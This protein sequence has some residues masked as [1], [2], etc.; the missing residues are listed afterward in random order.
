MSR[1]GRQDADE[2]LLMALACGATVE[3]AAQKAGISRRTAQ[4]RLADSAFRQ[5]LAERRAD[6]VQRTAG[7]LTAAS[8]ESVKTL[9]TLQASPNPAGVRL[10]AARS[11]L[12][13]AV[14]LREASEW[15]ERLLALE[16]RLG[17]NG[18]T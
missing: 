13:M 16:Q 8:L 7:M 11:V 15:E 1:R 10:G 3:N 12:D 18:A 5:R 17:A 2:A 14:K 6:M 4:R 9:L